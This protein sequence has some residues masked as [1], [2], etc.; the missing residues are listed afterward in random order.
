VAS[1]ALDQVDLILF[2]EHTLEVDLMGIEFA[3]GTVCVVIKSTV[4]VVFCQLKTMPST[5]KN[6]TK[7]TTRVNQPRAVK[8]K[9]IVLVS[10]V[11]KPSKKPA[12]KNVFGPRKLKKSNTRRLKQTPATELVIRKRKKAVVAQKPDNDEAKWFK[13][14]YRIQYGKFGNMTHI[15]EN[16]KASGSY[17]TPEQYMHVMANYD[18]LHKEHNDK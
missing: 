12:K 13:E 8:N 7:P 17:L 18:R 10:I 6:Q 1:F 15:K 14:Y 3:T 9:K 5:V 4:F 11:E 16:I 2:I